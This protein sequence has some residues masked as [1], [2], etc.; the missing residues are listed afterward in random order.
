MSLHSNNTLTETAGVSDPLIGAELE[1]AKEATSLKLYSHVQ[2]KEKF[3]LAP[4]NP[5]GSQ[6]ASFPSSL[7]MVASAVVWG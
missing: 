2:F 4:L 5:P 1:L 7:G 6:K 3:Q